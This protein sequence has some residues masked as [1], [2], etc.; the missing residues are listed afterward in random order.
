VRADSNPIWMADIEKAGGGLE[1]PGWLE[2]GHS[3]RA[4]LQ[5]S[6]LYRVRVSAFSKHAQVA[7]AAQAGTAKEHVWLLVGNGGRRLY[8]CWVLQPHPLLFKHACV[9][10]CEDVQCVWHC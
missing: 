5:L 10:T 9:P 4:G 7:L 1:Q 3:G 2:G 6:L 8:C